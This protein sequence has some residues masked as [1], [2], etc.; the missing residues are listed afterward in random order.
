MVGAGVLRECLLDSSVESVLT[1]GRRVTGIKHEKLRE[2]VH[3]NLLDF[4]A[5][6]GEL[7]GYD[8][9]FFCLGITSLGVT[10]AE[11]RKVT[12]GITMAA[13]ETL[14]KLSPAM[15]F[16]YVTGAGTDSSEMGRVMWA[17]VKG[18]TENALLRFPFK[19]V[20]IFRP[21]AIQPMHGVTSRTKLY[22][23]FYL[24]FAPVLA[25]GKRWFPKYVTTTEVIGRAMLKVAK[26]GS[27]KRVLETVDINSL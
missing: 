23:A 17:R 5:I 7:S 15:T 26:Q 16:V 25:A 10:E 2:V 12:Y 24:L 22:R 1:V 20:Y 8:A 13:A 14:A 19:G 6:E 9:C 18:Q 4:T 11:Y 27:A 3:K 21:G